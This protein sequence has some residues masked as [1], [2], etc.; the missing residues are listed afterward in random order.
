MRPA[1][2]FQNHRG[3]SSFFRQID[4]QD[5]YITL[6]SGLERFATTECVERLTPERL[7]REFA[8]TFYTRLRSRP[9]HPAMPARAGSLRLPVIAWGTVLTE[10]FA[11]D[12]DGPGARRMFRLALA[13]DWAART[14]DFTFE[15]ERDG[16]IALAPRR[17]SASLP[18]RD[19]KDIASRVSLE[20]LAS[21]STGSILARLWSESHECPVCGGK[22][23]RRVDETG[24]IE[25]LACGHEGKLTSLDHRLVRKHLGELTSLDHRLVRKYLG[26]LRPGPTA[27]EETGPASQPLPVTVCVGLGG[28]HLSTDYLERSARL[29]DDL[30]FAG[31][32][33]HVAVDW[34]GIGPTG[35][36]FGCWH[37]K[38]LSGGGFKALVEQ[39]AH[40]RVPIES[41][42]GLDESLRRRS[43][44]SVGREP[45]RGVCWR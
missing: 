8:Q 4:L 14:F 10:R 38:A 40:G 26:A 1:P 23:H 5:L 9:E 42:T 27:A 7:R 45:S 43:R 11:V 44:R 33:D 41:T 21:K 39:V 34:V 36:S 25:C 35:R 24:L 12:P 13:R 28:K 32:L 3:F 37:A 22:K 30:Y 29:V 16:D 18:D 19:P 20:F 15:A 6:G 17:F 31:H 2:L